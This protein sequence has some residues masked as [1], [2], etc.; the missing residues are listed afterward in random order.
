MSICAAIYQYHKL[1]HFPITFIITH[2]CLT[3]LEKLW[4]SFGHVFIKFKAMLPLL[5]NDLW[6]IRFRVYINFSQR[7]YFPL[8]R[9][10][11]E[12]VIK[13]SNCS[14]FFKGIILFFSLLD[15]LIT[16]LSNRVEALYHFVN[17]PLYNLKA[18]QFPSQN[19]FANI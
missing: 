2:F 19:H 8:F 9:E 7:Y 1:V 4:L 10:C 18:S 15:T 14:L 6:F 11:F 12:A 13:T 5:C 17:T 3:F 16:E